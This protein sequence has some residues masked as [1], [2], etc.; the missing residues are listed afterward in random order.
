MEKYLSPSCKK[1]KYIADKH[2]EENESG[3][4]E[5]KLINSETAWKIIQDL[6]PLYHD[7]VCSNKSLAAIEE[8][9][10]ECDTCKKYLDSINN[11]FIQN[12]TDKIAEQSKVN[13]WKKIKKK[14]FRKNVIIS[15]V[16]V[17]CAIAVLLGG[18][19]LVFYHEMPVPYV[20]GLVNV[21]MTQ[22]G[23]IDVMVSEAGHH[24]FVVII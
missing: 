9:L 21:N 20:N 2:Y 8:H 23:R 6:L 22:D 17:L 11:D 24:I 13:T 3:H 7:N 14:L 5:Q 4:I 10:M 12:T 1:N 19:L 18:F 15:I 16:S